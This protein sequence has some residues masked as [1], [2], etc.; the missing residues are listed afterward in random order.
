MKK[1][2]VAKRLAVLYFDY[3]RTL[4][5]EFDV[6]VCLCIYIPDDDL[7]EVETCRWDVTDYYLLLT[8]QL[9]GRIL[10]SESIAGNMD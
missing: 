2:S 1:K 4:L 3:T 5:T 6:L 8:V 10:Y 9:M 7:V